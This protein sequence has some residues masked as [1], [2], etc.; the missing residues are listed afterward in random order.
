MSKYS[1]AEREKAEAEI[2]SY[3]KRELR[4]YRTAKG[5][6][7]KSSFSNSKENIRR[8]HKKQRVQKLKDAKSFVKKVSPKLLKFFA[9]GNDVFPRKITPKLQLIESDTWESELF[10]LASLTW[11]VPVSQGY[12]R[13]M[14]FLVWDEYNNKLIGIF[15][16]G[17]PV[18]NLSARD[19]VI[20]WDAKQRKERLVNVMDA[21]VLGSIPPYNALLCGKMI[22]CLIRSKDVKNAF[23]KKY[24][25]YKGIITGK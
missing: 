2:M 1:P 19:K 4:Y 8:L 16:L 12:G 25:N 22:A 24:G 5:V 23:S 14:R 7:S 17:D 9:S 15:A 21:Y 6:S 18:F 11:S 10:R 20:G 13:R 3:I